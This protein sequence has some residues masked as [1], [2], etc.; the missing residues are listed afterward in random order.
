MEAW[1]NKYIV[2]YPKIGFFILGIH[3]AKA[4]LQSILARPNG[5]RKNCIPKDVGLPRSYSDYL[6][7]YQK[8]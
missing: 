1:G 3:I 6:T 2:T 8:S 4:S 5:Q 7:A